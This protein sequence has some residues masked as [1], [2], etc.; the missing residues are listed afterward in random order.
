MSQDIGSSIMCRACMKVDGVLLPMY[1][2]NNTITEK[3]FPDKLAD[4]ASIHIDKYDG[5]P[6]VLCAKCAY[7]T[8]AFHEFKLQVRATEKKLR[9]MF[10]CPVEP[11][12]EPKLKLRGENTDGKHNDFPNESAANSAY[13]GNM[14]NFMKQSSDVTDVKPR[15]EDRPSEIYVAA[16][17]EE[18]VSNA[19][20]MKTD[21][22]NDIKN[23]LQDESMEY[24]LLYVSEANEI[25][26]DTSIPDVSLSKE[27]LQRRQD[28]A[29]FDNDECSKEQSLKDSLVDHPAY[30]WISEGFPMDASEMV[31]GSLNVVDK[32]IYNPK[33]RMMEINDNGDSESDYR[34]DPDP[35]NLLG[36]LNDTIMRIK[37]IK[38]E[39]KCTLYQCTLCMESYDELTGILSHTIETHVPKNGPF[40]CVVCEKDCSSIR[41]LRNHAKSHS[42]K[43]PYTCFVCNKAYSMKRYLKRHMA[44][45]TDLPRHRCPKCGN[46]FNVK[47]DLEA[48]MTSHVYTG[49]EFA[50][51]QCPRVF[52]HK[53]N[54]KRHL[55]AH[56]DP[57]GIHLPKFPC[58]ICGKRFLNNRTLQTHIRVHTGEKPFE[59]QICKKTFSQR[60]NLFNHQRI[61]SNPRS[62]TCEVCGKRFNQRATLRDH[63]LLHTGEKP[64]VCNVCGIAFTFSAALRRHLW[65]HATDKPFGCEIC[66]ARFVGKYDIKRHMKIHTD[67]PKDRRKRHNQREQSIDP[68]RSS[69]HQLT[70]RSSSLT[71]PNC[72]RQILEEDTKIFIDQVLL[73]N[74]DSTQIRHRERDA[75]KENVDA[76][77]NLIEYG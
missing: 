38:T 34:M 30:T 43:Y 75:E 28:V 62:Y 60:G 72:C 9:K 44:C 40:F 74:D 58:D 56:L 45:H 20:I 63:G 31:T 76:L 14:E 11:A 33:P 73:L 36:S 48:H 7:R 10:Q 64:Y 46:R 59:C 71:T 41:E 26:F 5:L 17:G 53:G 52:K 57:N 19:R 21:I 22:T 23:I 42:G 54:Y 29:S 35:E 47:S 39:G 1:G 8:D 66:N 27:I 49:P 77:L 24:T 13:Q 68:T 32:S 55:I 15:T 67:R 69:V 25:H 65:S 12:I 37:E 16:T 51:S 70:E 61:H 6:S 50:C 18:N 4:L 3:N 2:A